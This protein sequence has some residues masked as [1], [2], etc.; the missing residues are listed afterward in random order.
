[1]KKGASRKFFKKIDWNI[2]FLSLIAIYAT[3]IL[4][5]LFT[6]RGANSFWYLTVRPSITPPNWV[7]PVV[8][9]ILFFLIFLALYLCLVNVKNKKICSKV[10]LCFGI[11]LVL[12]FLW[13]YFFFGLRNP[14]LAFVDLIL[15]WFSIISIIYS[16]WKI[17]KRISILLVPYFLW[18][19][20]AGVLNY[21]I[22]FA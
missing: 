16:S 7:F 8:W 4:G 12:N 15:L 18:V 20:F 3:A 9:N 17:D 14:K 11:N 22:A 13:S 19:T 21:L 5:G 10:E 6:S 2:L 1:M